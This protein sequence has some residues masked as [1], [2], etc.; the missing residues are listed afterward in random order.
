MLELAGLI[1]QK[2]IP[3]RTNADA[4]VLYEQC[5]LTQQTRIKARYELAYLLSTPA[6]DLDMLHIALSHILNC[7]DEI[8][9][10]SHHLNLLPAIERLA[11]LIWGKINAAIALTHPHLALRIEAHPASITTTTPQRA[12]IGTP[13][14]RNS[15]CPCGSEKKYKNCCR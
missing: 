12:Y 9:S 11:T 8:V 6:E 7:K 5:I 10:T 13:V 1:V 14:G 4:Q 3:G 2:L 15:P